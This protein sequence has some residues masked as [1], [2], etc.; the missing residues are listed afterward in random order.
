MDI[1]IIPTPISI[2]WA[3]PPCECF[4]VASIGKNWEG[5]KCGYIP[6]TEKTKNALRLLERTVEII[7]VLKPKI[8]FIENPRCVT[9]KVLPPLLDKYGLHYTQHT[10]TYCQ[11]GDTRMK[12]TDI[13]T[14]CDIKFKP[15]CKN[16]DQCHERAPRGAK[17]GTQGLKGATERGVIP[18]QLMEDI[19]DYFE[20]EV[21]T[22]G[23]V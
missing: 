15:P 14:N 3:S 5:G 21:M 16:G 2:L 18:K 23:K 7:S 9:R 6:K 1:N 4:S 12:P 17:T 20:K 19:F 22:D 13:W 10:V 11:Y 8:W